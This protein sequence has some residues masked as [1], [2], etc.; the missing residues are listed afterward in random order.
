MQTRN[1]K[2]ILTALR[3][4]NKELGF[5]WLEDSTHTKYTPKYEDVSVHAV[6]AYMGSRDLA[7]FFLNLR[8]K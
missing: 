4:S 8:S 6:K 2:I 5:A 7:P 3:L 1:P